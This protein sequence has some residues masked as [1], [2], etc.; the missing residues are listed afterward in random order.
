MILSYFIFHF[1]NEM[2]II[3]ICFKLDLYVVPIKHTCHSINGIHIFEK[4][5]IKF[6]IL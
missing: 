1:P 6:S 5:V 4:W 3:Y 2:D